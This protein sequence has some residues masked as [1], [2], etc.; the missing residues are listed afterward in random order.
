VPE[1]RDR[2][3]AED[4]RRLAVLPDHV[5]VGEAALA[6]KTEHGPG[7]EVYVGAVNRLPCLVALRDE[8]AS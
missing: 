6:F 2:T 3:A 7:V 8:R 1:S 4:E 5:K